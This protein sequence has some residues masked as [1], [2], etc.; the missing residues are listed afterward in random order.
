MKY[1][2]GKPRG[3]TVL[4]ASPET[5]HMAAGE[6]NSPRTS[7]DGSSGIH[8]RT[9]GVSVRVGRST[10][11]RWRPSH[12]AEDVGFERATFLRNCTQLRRITV[13]NSHNC[14]FKYVRKDNKAYAIH[15][16]GQAPR[17][18]RCNTVD[19]PLVLTAKASRRMV[20]AFT[21]QHPTVRRS[22]RPRV[23]P[24]TS[25]A[26][27]RSLFVG[28][29]DD[30]S[31]QQLLELVSATFEVDSRLDRG[32]V[33]EAVENEQRVRAGPLDLPEKGFDRGPVRRER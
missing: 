22:T 1:H 12:H 27:L 21:I 25:V 24:S 30:R 16:R 23:S 10:T 29:D 7:R 14:V 32:I 9:R 28:N 19:V 11:A 15:P 8:T 18:S 33:T 6:C 3:F 26:C 20:A 13:F 31:V 17:H 5:G 2:G 4:A